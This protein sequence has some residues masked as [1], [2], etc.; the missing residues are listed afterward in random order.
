[1]EY[2]HINTEGAI[3]SLNKI[4][5]ALYLFDEDAI[6]MLRGLWALSNSDQLAD[7]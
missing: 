3:S 4:G 7:F 1:M 5:V 6:R 2:Q